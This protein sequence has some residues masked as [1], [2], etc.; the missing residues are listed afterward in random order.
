MLLALVLAQA[1]GNPQGPIFS[2]PSTLSSFAFFEAFPASGAGT[3]TACSTTPPTGAR[4]EVLTYA[5][6]GPK[7]CTKGVNGL[8]GTLIAD[9][10]LSSLT[11][12]PRVE[13][14]VDG[15]LGLLVEASAMTINIQARPLCN[16]AW[17]DVGTPDCLANATTGPWGTTTMARI[18]DN[19]AAAPEGRSQV[20]ATTSATR[21]TAY[22]YVK[23]GTATS[24]AIQLTGTGSAAG[25]CL[26]S[27]TGLSATT[28]SIVECT[29]AAPYAGTLTAV[30]AGVVVGTIGT[31]TGT[32]FVEGCDVKPSA[33]YRTSLNDTTT[34]A[35][36][37]AT[38]EAAF[39]GLSISSAN[40]LSW[41][42]NVQHPSGN[43]G[44]L[45]GS[46]PAVVADASNRTQLYRANTNVQNCDYLS[47]SGSRSS[48]PVIA[49]Y[50]AGLSYRQGCSYSGPGAGST[51]SGYRNGVLTATS[52]GGLT[53]AFTATTVLPGALGAAPT[54]IPAD[55][56]VSRLKVDQSPLGGL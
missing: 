3:T 28:S 27:I 23:A 26:G 20:V 54:A 34:V 21:F 13:F 19:D 39:N 6:V 45:W 42:A 7:T 49:A 46:G 11:T 18:T 48:G 16:A 38:D 9:G 15:F 8:R 33:I 32:L 17:S 29:S 2:Q 35:I 10:D 44:A 5:G 40:G 37:R 36:T 47:T 14:D 31:D 52:A 30:T 56:I 55:G 22:C 51:I 41:S 25:D 24:A 50:V 4:G 53:S 1:I 12:L 43:G